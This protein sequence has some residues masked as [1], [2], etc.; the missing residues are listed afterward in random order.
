MTFRMMMDEVRLLYG[1][2]PRWFCIVTHR[3]P[4]TAVPSCIVCHGL[5][6]HSKS[7]SYTLLHAR[8]TGAVIAGKLTRPLVHSSSVIVIETAEV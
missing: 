2:L 5:V 7:A 3:R 6:Q 8:N 1:T 4:A